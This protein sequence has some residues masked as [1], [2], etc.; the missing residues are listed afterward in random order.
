MNN[1]IL[2]ALANLLKM[3]ISFVMSVFLSVCLSLCPSV[4][5]SICPSV[6]VEQL[7]PHWTDFHEI[8]YLR[9]F[10]KSVERI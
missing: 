5:L 4:C 6:R 10:R 7:Y 8:R 1:L 9:I 3:T 2:G